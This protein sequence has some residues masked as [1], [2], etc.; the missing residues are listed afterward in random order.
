LTVA[1]AQDPDE[2]KEEIGRPHY[3]GGVEIAE[4]TVDENKLI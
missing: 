2:M 1:E 3:D 4:A